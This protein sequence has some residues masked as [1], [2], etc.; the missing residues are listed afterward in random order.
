M[1]IIVRAE[2]GKNARS[3]ALELQRRIAESVAFM[4]AFNVLGVEVEIR[5][6]KYADM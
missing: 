3:A 5:D 1:R 6:F 4:T 2:Y